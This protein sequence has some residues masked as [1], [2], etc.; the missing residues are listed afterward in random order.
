MPLHNLLMNLGKGI[1]QMIEGEVV[2]SA[3]VGFDDAY[4]CLVDGPTV[5]VVQRKMRQVCEELA[6]KM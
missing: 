6:P 5:G 2:Q 4:N 1:K 3:S